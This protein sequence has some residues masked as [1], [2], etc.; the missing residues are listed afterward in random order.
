M[1]HAGTTVTR[2]LLAAFVVLT[3]ALLPGLAAAQPPGYVYPYPPP[4]PP[5]APAQYQPPSVAQPR[6]APVFD[7][8]M[9]VLTWDP[10]RFAIAAEGRTTWPIDGGAQRLASQRTVDSSGVSLQADVFRPLPRLALRMD[11]GWEKGSTTS[12]QSETS[13]EEH[14]DTNLFTL[15]ASLRFDLLRWLSPY[16]R[17]AFGLGW[18]K[19]TVAATKDRDV[20]EQGS[21]G[22]GLFLRTPGLRLWQGRWAPA[23]G[24]LLMVEGGY[25]VATGSDF[26]LK[27]TLA[28][29]S[30]APIPTNQVALGHVGRSAPYLRLAFG[31]AF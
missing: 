25:T 18:D 22:A 26:V 30:G 13:L 12:L 21:A 6:R 5:P 17:L 11:A 27:P 9:P 3:G 14:V 8:D 19:V 15:G 16:A 29:A 24:L 2:V 10:L 1:S 28:S 31:L 23:F 4:A 20:F 7:T